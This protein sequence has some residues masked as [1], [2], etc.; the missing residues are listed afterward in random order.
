[1]PVEVLR[2]GT[3]SGLIRARLMG[4]KAAKGQVITF[5]DAHCEC[6]EGWLDPMLARIA[7]NRYAAGEGLS[8]PG[9][10]GW[11]DS[12]TFGPVN[13]S[14]A[15]VGFGTFSWEVRRYS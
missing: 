15:E 14:A 11:Q 9:V 12:F 3:R 2:T 1:M 10:G 5:L 4:A 7:E 13:F 8:T 6:T